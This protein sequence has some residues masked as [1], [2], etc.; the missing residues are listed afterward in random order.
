MVVVTG[1]N[2]NYKLMHYFMKVVVIH[3]QLYKHTLTVS[4]DS[5]STTYSSHSNTLK[6]RNIEVLSRETIK[7][8]TPTSQHLR[9]HRLSLL[10]QLSIQFYVPVILFYDDHA[11]SS[12]DDD[13]LERSNLLK[14][15]LGECLS[16]Y[17]PLAGTIREDFSVDCNDEGVEYV[18]ARVDCKLS[19]AI[20]KPTFELLNQLLPFDPYG[21]NVT[22]RTELA[23]VGVKFNIFEC[24]GVAISVCVS[25]RIADG[26]SLVTFLNAWAA[27]SRASTSTSEADDQKQQYP[28][29]DA[30]L[31]FPP[32]DM[33]GFKLQTADQTSTGYE[34]IVTKR[35][36]FD[37][38]NIIA[39]KQHATSSLSQSGVGVC[40]EEV[41]KYPPT[42]VQV[43]S[44]LIWKTFMTAIRSKS[45]P[46][47]MCVAIHS[48]NLRERMVPPLPNH[49]FGNLWQTT[50][51]PTT[52]DGD[53]NFGGL[54]R[55]IGNSVREINDEYVRRII[56]DDGFVDSNNK[57]RERTI[58]GEIEFFGFSSWSRFPFYEADFGWGKPTWVCTPIVP[59]KNV[60]VLMSTKEGDGIEAWVNLLE[61]DMAIFE[62]DLDL[63]S[64]VSSVF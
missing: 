61:K 56:M 41:Q 17:Y 52:V 26:T 47:K 19:E 14:K 23:P 12:S 53:K 44:A 28:I 16:R 5:I 64:F 62:R 29:F 34:K 9:N 30:A 10:D 43:V 6:M 18:E 38:F 51:A 33:P 50:M 24:G 32:R 20:K 45:K 25:H 49:F 8:S 35:F 21:N 57:E 11:R 31:L 60:C 2:I 13:H 15:S 27:M 54:V 4:K 40:C 58:K 59:Y 63:L 46:G 7:P 55:L 37:K 1:K 39:L 3:D 22:G 42:R 48:V 36:V